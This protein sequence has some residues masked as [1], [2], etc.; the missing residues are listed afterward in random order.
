[1]KARLPCFFVVRVYGCNESKAGVIRLGEVLA[2]SQP[3]F[4][5]LVFALNTRADSESATRADMVWQ[6]FA[7]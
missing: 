3:K 7:A 6:D 5:A 1:M 4:T 2:R